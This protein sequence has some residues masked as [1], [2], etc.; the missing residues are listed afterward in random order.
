[1]IQIGRITNIFGGGVVQSAPVAAVITA[2][3]TCVTAVLAIPL[4]ASVAA[5]LLALATTLF[6]LGYVLF[7]A[8]FFVAACASPFVAYQIRKG[9]EASRATSDNLAQAARI[10]ANLDIARRRGVP[11]GQ[12]GELPQPAPIRVQAT[13]E[14]DEQK[15]ISEW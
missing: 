5:V 1:M 3:A 6:A 15:M 7:G 10:R 9:Y 13:V 2:I 12:R 14:R 8:G 11:G 4:L